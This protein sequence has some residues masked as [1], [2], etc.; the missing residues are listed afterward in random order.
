MAAKPKPIT[1][2]ANRATVDDPLRNVLLLQGGGALGA[3]QAGAYE[4]LSHHHYT[5]D[6]VIGVSIG[7]INASLIAGNAPEHRL[8]RL[9]EFWARITAPPAS[10]TPLNAPFFADIEQKLGAVNAVMF[11]QP[12]FFR[13]RAPFDFFTKPTPL[14]FYD[15]SQLR[16][17]LEELVDF[18]RINS[19]ATRLSVGAVQIRTGN[20]IYFDSKT[21]K[22]TADHIMASGALPPGFPPVEI[23]GEAYWDGGL[24]SNTPLEYMMS[25]HPRQHSLV[26]QI[27]LFPARGPMPTTLD[28]V[29]E[30]D[31]DIRYSSRTR[32]STDA[33]KRRQDLRCQVSAFI[34]RLPVDLHADPVAAFLHEL[35][36]PAQIDVVHLIYRPEHPQGSQKDFQFDRVTAEQRWAD[37]LQ[38]AERALHAAPWRA[39][40]PPGIGM[41][42][43]DITKPTE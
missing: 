39:P 12:G 13:P 7:A 3:Y 35:A 25:T 32:S 4:A 33:E 24:V 1:N 40:Y 14:S 26:F 19:G 23:D 36:C 16:T 27:D 42:T 9:R 38:D 21:Q 6:W 31:K 30:R 43:F 37:G 41:R 5:P 22:I 2:P 20:M 11:G 18:D 8:S 10:L 28:E 29:A 15:T 34:E 17:T